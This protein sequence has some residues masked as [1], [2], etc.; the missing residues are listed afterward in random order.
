LPGSRKNRALSAKKMEGGKQK[1][2][3]QTSSETL[4]EPVTE[5]GMTAGAINKRVGFLGEQI[6]LHGL[7]PHDCRHYWATS[8]TRGGTNLKNLQDAGGWTSPA[9]PM[10]YIES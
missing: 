4:G 9:M 7:S 8:A 10:R 3:T 1:A 6:G 5:N 2:P